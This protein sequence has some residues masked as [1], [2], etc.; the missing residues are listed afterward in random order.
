MSYKH[1]MVGI[2]Q[3]ICHTPAL[4]FGDLRTSV[5]GGVRGRGRNNEGG[6]S[7][8][9]QGGR[10]NSVHGGRAGAHGR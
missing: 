3:S 1:A 8:A 5:Q 2:V 10:Q 4:A 9:F 7:Q 6:L